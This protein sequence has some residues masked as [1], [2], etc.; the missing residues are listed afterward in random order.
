MNQLH[1]VA[2]VCTGLF[3]G[4]P[5]LAGQSF[6]RQSF[7][8][9]SF[10]RQSFARQS[11]AKQLRRVGAVLSI[12]ALAWPG[13]ALAQMAPSGSPHAFGQKAPP[14]D[15]IFEAPEAGPGAILVEV[16][17]G[18]DKPLAGVPVTLKESFDSVG[19]G[20]HQGGHTRVTD[21]SGVARF[22]K[23]STSLRTS[24]TPEI[25]FM[26]G[27]YTLEAFR[28]SEKVGLRAILHVYP[29]THNIQEAVVGMRGF[30]YVTLRE[31]AIHFELLYRVFNMGSQAW[32]PE[33]VSIRLPEGATGFT[34]GDHGARFKESGRSLTLEGTFPPGQ[35]DVPV[36]FQIP[37]RNSESEV[38]SFGVLPHVA[39]LRVLAEA[40][41]GLTLI[42]PGFEPVQKADGPA[43]TPVWVTRRVMNPGEGELG[44]VAVELNGL[45]TIGP[46][47]Y[48]ALVFAL[49]LAS[50][51][52]Y[53]A[54]SYKRGKVS[55]GDDQKRI[56]EA[57]QVLLSELD[58]LEKAKT[59]EVVGPQTYESTRRQILD[60]LARLALRGA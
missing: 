38:Y 33:G 16:R 58:L 29:A 8:R 47:R 40:A 2:R 24:F 30:L 59:Q 34:L 19:E 20:K 26:G 52:L 55:L 49:L 9:Q 14:E 44:G 15:G 46:E 3:L 36:Q 4:G 57:K 12:S 10:A 45:P 6:A 32:V 53:W 18:E 50:S 42:V 54:L 27:D 13:A 7:A 56:L 37:S 51:G 22:D 31:N 43:G 41:P 1:F 48:Y 5:F 25:K 11:F 17:D 23:L 39:E 28:A 21:P 60:A 35:R